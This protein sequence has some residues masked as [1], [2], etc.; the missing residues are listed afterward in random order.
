M[1]SRYADVDPRALG[2]RIRG[3]SRMASGAY[4]G[5]SGRPFRNWQG[6]PCTSCCAGGQIVAE[7]LRLAGD[8]RSGCPDSGRRR[9]TMR[10]S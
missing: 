5:L 3:P 1:D 6:A 8:S 4:R 2:M 7:Q 10:L 9:V